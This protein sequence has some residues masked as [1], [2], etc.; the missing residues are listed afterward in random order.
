MRVVIAVAAGFYRESLSA[1][2]AARP[3]IEVVGAAADSQGAA[4]CIAT[5]QPEV[6]VVDV[7]L[8]P[9]LGLL[10]SADAARY[11]RTRI[12]ALGVRDDPLEVAA[13][14]EMGVAGYVPPEAGVDDL[15]QILFEAERNEVRSTPEVTAFLIRRVAELACSARLPLA[16]DGAQLTGRQQEVAALV[17]NGL[18]NKEI[19]RRLG[20]SVSTVKNHVHNVLAELG[21]SS[22][23]E[24]ARWYR[25]ERAWSPA[26][27][28]QNPS[29]SAVTGGPE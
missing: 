19:A 6:A 13:C 18:M 4:A 12:V 24:L 3:G 28:S 10:A 7:D 17:A 14:A 27:R 8:I 15:V 26:A 11:S 29:R 2:L 25:S 16:P 20:V 22:R 21:L 9:T 1:V 23:Y 5:A